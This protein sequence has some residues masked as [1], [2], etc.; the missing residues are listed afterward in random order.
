MAVGC[1]PRARTLTWGRRLLNVLGVGCLTLMF[2]MQ[3][4]LSERRVFYLV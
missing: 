3:H 1:A 4:R 2:A